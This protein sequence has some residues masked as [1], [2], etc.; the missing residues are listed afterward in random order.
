MFSQGPT[1][2]GGA[3]RGLAD[4]RGRG[5][6]GDMRQGPGSGDGA[7]FLAPSIS[8]TLMR[9]QQVSEVAQPLINEADMPPLRHV[10]TSRQQRAQGIAS[11][12]Q[13]S[14]YRPQ[15]LSNPPRQLRQIQQ[16]PRQQVGRMWYNGR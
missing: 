11:M 1:G 7:D 14:P 9:P 6:V 5:I 16:M 4:L 13:P 10:D 12:L 2:P 15:F 8:T 3:N